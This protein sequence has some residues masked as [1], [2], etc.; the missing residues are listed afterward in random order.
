MQWFFVFLGLFLGG[1]AFAD[2]N[3]PLGEYTKSPLEAMEHAY[4]YS[5]KNTAIGILIAYGDG[6]GKGV[7]PQVIGDQFVRE[8][9][10]R[11]YKARYFFYREAKMTGM[12]IEYYIG[13][14]ALGPWDVDKAALNIKEATNMM[15]AALNIHGDWLPNSDQR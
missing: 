9:N 6:N 2:D 14:S 10:R 8:L 5:F 15:D 7:T 4:N 3:K 11:G 12:I 13:H 1:N